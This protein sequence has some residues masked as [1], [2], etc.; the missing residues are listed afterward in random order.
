MQTYA[1]IFRF[2]KR[3]TAGD[4]HRLFESC[5]RLW[6]EIISPTWAT[7]M[8]RCWRRGLVLAGNSSIGKRPFLFLVVSIDVCDAIFSCSKKVGPF[9]D[10]IKYSYGGVFFEGFWYLHSIFNNGNWL[11]SLSTNLFS[12]S[13]VLFCLHAEKPA[14]LT[15]EVDGLRVL[16]PNR[17][18]FISRVPDALVDILSVGSTTAWPIMICS[19]NL[20]R[21]SVNDDTPSTRE[22]DR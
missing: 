14:N 13:R 9:G 16:T 19:A 2:S 10:W 8:V 4:G 20:R 18:D 21:R 6:Y 7:C 5:L 17:H 15:S 11:A 1:L 22:I 3:K 12:C